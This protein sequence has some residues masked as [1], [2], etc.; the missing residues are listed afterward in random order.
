MVGKKS[1]P[2]SGKICFDGRV[3]SELEP[4]KTHTEIGMVFKVALLIQSRGKR[5]VPLKMFTN[6]NKAVIKER[7]DFV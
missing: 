1:G 2:E 3:Y 5:R 7:V 4:M 6:D